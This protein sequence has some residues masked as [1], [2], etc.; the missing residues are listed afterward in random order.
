MAELH[1]S[2]KVNLEQMKNVLKSKQINFLQGDESENDSDIMLSEIFSIFYI[3]LDDYN[4]TILVLDMRKDKNIQNEFSA[5]YLY[6]KKFTEFLNPSIK[7]ERGL[8]II[9]ECFV[10]F[11]MNDE[12]FAC[13]VRIAKKG[14]KFPSASEEIRNIVELTMVECIEDYSIL[15]NKLSLWDYLS[16]IYYWWHFLKAVNGDDNLLPH[17]KDSI[18]LFLNIFTS[19]MLKNK[20]YTWDLSFQDFE[21]KGGTLDNTNIEDGNKMSFNS[22]IL[23]GANLS[24]SKLNRANLTE[25]SLREIILDRANLSETNISKAIL[26]EIKCRE[27]KYNYSIMKGSMLIRIEADGA[28]FD[29]A[30][31]A[32]SII[33]GGSF[34]G[35]SFRN[36]NLSNCEINHGGDFSRADFMPGIG[37][38]TNI[39]GIKFTA[40][41]L[42]QAKFNS[43]EALDT[44][45]LS[46]SMMGA[47]FKSTRF[48]NA[49]FSDTDL[50]GSYFT[51][52]DVKESRFHK[53]TFSKSNLEGA[54]FEQCYFESSNLSDCYLQGVRFIDCRLKGVQMQRIQVDLNT[55][56]EGSDL[57][58]AN[59]KGMKYSME[60]DDDELYGKIYQLLENC[61]CLYNAEG[62]PPEVVQEIKRKKP[63]LLWEPMAEKLTI[64]DA[65]GYTVKL[66]GLI[67]VSGRPNHVTIYFNN[68]ETHDA[69][70]EDYPTELSVGTAIVVS[71]KVERDENDNPFISKASYRNHILINN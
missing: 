43:I 40:V 54:I 31:L 48:I 9:W 35:A 39:N 14:K 25:C 27:A 2:K 29:N 37:E 57:S 45:F 51:F 44:C 11:K 20:R 1:G 17:N 15:S 53:T 58:F 55:S 34:T 68:E 47:E 38:P 3:R 62:I 10:D 49:D 12:T 70:L 66:N 71:V 8:K 42:E 24:D 63:F 65:A 30:D 50:T 60:D 13:L 69:I 6:N 18:Q 36:T 56:F 67:C 5:N 41:K 19:D 46:A 33:S 16:G 26:I 61:S 28:V 4:D 23:K 59:L 52:A 21:F 64:E 7:V 32:E 22:A